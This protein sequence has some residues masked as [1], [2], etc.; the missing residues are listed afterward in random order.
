[1]PHF[2]FWSWPKAFIGT[3]DEALAKIDRVEKDT[4]WEKKID[5]AVWRGTVWFNSIANINLRP[6]LM[7]QTKGK[8]W[9]DVEDLKWENQGESAQ[10][11]IVIEDFCKYKYV[12]YT[13]VSLIPSHAH[14]RKF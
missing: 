5:K 13:E 12:I 6:Q 4:P 2:S 9:A 14:T 11:A 8:E 3:M 7:E 10:N 1:M